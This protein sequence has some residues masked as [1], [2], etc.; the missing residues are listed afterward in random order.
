[1]ALR[2]NG[3]GRIAAGWIL[4]SLVVLVGCGPKHPKPDVICPGKASSEEAL[5]ALQAHLDKVVPVAIRDTYCRVSYMDKENIRRS[6]RLPSFKIFL[7]PPHNI[8]MQGIPVGGPQG[9]VSMGSNQDE[10][11]VDIRPEDSYWWGKW[12]EVSDA[13]QL[14]ISPRIVLE[15]L[16]LVDLDCPGQW[17]LSHEGIY[18][19]LSLVNEANNITKRVFI[20]ACDYLPRKIEYLDADGETV[21]L[22]KLGVYKNFINEFS[23]PSRIETANYVDGEVT[24]SVELMIKEVNTKDYTESFRKKY[25]THRKPQGIANVYRITKEGTF[26]E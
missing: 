22:V 9:K 12:A 8:Y 6:Y 16:G 3:I 26:R 23:M 7:E 21:V 2:A 18:D 24:D 4:L 1:M 15:A 10:F 14:Q 11:W 20:N 5:A 19:I 17:E 25:F 13:E